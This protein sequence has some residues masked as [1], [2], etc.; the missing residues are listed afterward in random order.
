MAAH[1]AHLADSMADRHV[2]DS[3]D[4]ME[5]DPDEVADKAEDLD[6][7]VGTEAVAAE[8]DRSPSTAWRRFHNGNPD[9]ALAHTCIRRGI[10]AQVVLVRIFVHSDNF[11][12]RGFQDGKLALYD[13]CAGHLVRYRKHSDPGTLAELLESTCRLALGDTGDDP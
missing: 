2:A 10:R 11:D 4:N 7:A 12:H 5:A 13:R 6:A 8:Q 3:E 1:P 9:E